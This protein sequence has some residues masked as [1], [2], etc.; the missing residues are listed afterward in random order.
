MGLRRPGGGPG[1]PMSA[2]L[3]VKVPVGHGARDLADAVHGRENGIDQAL[4]ERQLG[5]VLGWGDSLGG[6]R[7][8]GSRAV[9]F[10]RI[11][12]EVTDLAAARQLLHELLPRLG[13]PA[14]TEIH[15]TQ[16]HASRVDVRTDAGWHSEP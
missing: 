3:H 7:H 2:F 5:S 1:A 14:G 4:A 8:D 12:I 9:A 13:T 15:W 11:D 10:R 6:A 16:D